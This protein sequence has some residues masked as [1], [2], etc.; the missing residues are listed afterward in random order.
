[1]WGPAAGA[2]RDGARSSG[3]QR[4]ARRE[5]ALLGPRSADSGPPSPLSVF[6]PSS[7]KR[8]IH[9]RGRPSAGLP[10]DR[11]PCRESESREREDQ[12]DT[13]ADL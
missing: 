7:S 8:L 11:W 10:A 1:M 9:C 3:C 5:P 13:C 12:R 6:R 4:G 2:D